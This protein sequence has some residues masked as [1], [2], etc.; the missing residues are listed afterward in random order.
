V[1]AYQQFH[2][3]ELAWSNISDEEV[4]RRAGEETNCAGK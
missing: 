4:K 1:W 2:V 3:E